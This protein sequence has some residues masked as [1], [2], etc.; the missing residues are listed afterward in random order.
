MS[1]ITNFRST[2][3]FRLSF[4]KEIPGLNGISILIY[5]SDQ[6]IIGMG[7]GRE[8]VLGRRFQL[9]EVVEGAVLIGT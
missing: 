7:V 5:S 3:K 2:V 1:K 9:G 8:T 6:L 4:Y